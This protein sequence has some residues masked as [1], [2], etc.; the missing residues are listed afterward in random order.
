[1]SVAT[2][3]LEDEKS[4]GPVTL[5]RSEGSGAVR[6]FL[7]RDSLVLHASHLPPPQILAFGLRV[8]VFSNQQQEKTLPQ[9]SLDE[10]DHIVSC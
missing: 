9:L 5:E 8:T 2:G 6:T 10:L 3:T 4:P 1:M 7:W